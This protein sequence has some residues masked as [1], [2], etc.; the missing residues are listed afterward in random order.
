MSAIEL[1]DRTLLVWLDAWRSPVFS[2]IMQA[3][4]WLGSLAVL[5]PLAL[6][7]GWWADR[8]S[9]SRNRFF[10]PVAVLGAA[11]IA[12][13]LKWV[14]GRDRP[15]LF[16]SLVAMPTDSSFPSA[17]AMQISALI[18]AWL[19]ATG[20]WRRFRPVAAGVVL[21]GIVGFSR[22]YLQVHFLSDVLCGIVIALCWVWLL[23]RPAWWGTNNA[24]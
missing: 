11:V 3:V 17:H 20:N 9:P 14:I 1:M 23:H 7:A 22:L 10:L 19:V 4:T 21:V 16:Q 13:L 2:A 15:T 8:G 18:A 5:L 12:Y 24:P 6:V